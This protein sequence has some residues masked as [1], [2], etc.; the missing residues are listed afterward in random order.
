MKELSSFISYIL[1]KI[2]FNILFEKLINSADF[3]GKCRL[4]VVKNYDII[5]VMIK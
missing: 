3:S 2:V 5:A 1:I 4:S